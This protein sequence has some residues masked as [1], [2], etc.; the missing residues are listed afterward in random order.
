MGP[1]DEQV[2]WGI[3]WSL[4][5]TMELFAKSGDGLGFEDRLVIYSLKMDREK[6]GL[7]KI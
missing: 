4:I 7:Q 1:E 5:W 2:V 3:L 6:G